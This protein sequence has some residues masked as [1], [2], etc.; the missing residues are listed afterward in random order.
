[1]EAKKVAFI[2][3]N[4]ELV[5]FKKILTIFATQFFRQWQITSQQ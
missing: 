5:G 4:L 3:K 2:R 1:M